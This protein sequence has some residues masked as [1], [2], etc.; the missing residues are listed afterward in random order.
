M[1]EIKPIYEH[2]KVG[3]LFFNI[4]AKVTKV[5]LKHR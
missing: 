2:S 4:T 5:L 1:T 3:N